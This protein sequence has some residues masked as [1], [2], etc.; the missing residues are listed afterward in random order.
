VLNI[1]IISIVYLKFVNILIL[2]LK[3]R[4]LCAQTAETEIKR[5]LIGTQSLRSVN[6]IQLIEYDDETNTLSKL[7]YEHN[8]GE[9]WHVNSSPSNKFTFLT[10]YNSNGNFCISD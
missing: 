4:A 7:L 2:I 1:I 3:T 10:C 8:K 9:I 5:F 6:E